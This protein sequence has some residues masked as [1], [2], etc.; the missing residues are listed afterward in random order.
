MTARGLVE[1][2]IIVPL[3]LPVLTL[4]QGPF[5][6]LATVGTLAV[7][8]FAPV[9]FYDLNLGRLVNLNIFLSFS[10]PFLSFPFLSFPFFHKQSTT[11]QT[12]GMTVPL[13]GLFVLLLALQPTAVRVP[14]ITLGRE[15]CATVLCHHS[16]PS[17]SLS[18][19]PLFLENYYIISFL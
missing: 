13:L 4:A 9:L 6:V 14:P 11:A 8:P 5:R 15:L 10:F 17:K 7:A 19:F 16:F 12:E 2:P 1:G 3:M 18:D